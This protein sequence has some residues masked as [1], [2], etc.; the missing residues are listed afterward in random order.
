ME[1]AHTGFGKFPRIGLKFSWDLELPLVGCCVLVSSS[2]R[3]LNDLH[4]CHLLR[5]EKVSA[6]NA[7]IFPEHF[8][9]WT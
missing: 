8:L 2:L 3:G 1:L 4:V 5:K 6:E 9:I 7:Q